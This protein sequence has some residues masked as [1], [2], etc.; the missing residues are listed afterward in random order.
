MHKDKLRLKYWAKVIASSW[1]FRA[2]IIFF[3]IESIWIALSGQYPMA[4]DEDFHLGIIRLYASHISPFW[5]SQPSNADRFGAVARDP[6]YLYQYLM[7]FPYRF[8]SLFTKDQT[9]MVILL[10]FIDI[11]FFGSSLV[12]FKR[13]MLKCGASATV[14]N[15]CLLL[16]VLLPVTPLLAAQINYDDLLMPLVAIAL[17]L[18]LRFDDLISRKKKID[19]K[20]GLQLLIICELASLV[21]YAFLPIFITIVGFLVI[22][23]WRNHRE[24]KKI[25]ANIAIDW[26]KISLKVRLGLSIA[27][28]I[29][30]GLFL[31][32]YGVNIVLYHT[33]TPDCAQ[34]LTV[35][36]CSQYGPWIRNYT[37]ELSNVAGPHN[38]ITFTREW[39]YGMW[40]RT[41]FSV[42]GSNINYETRGPLVLPGIGSIVLCA[43]GGLGFLLSIKRLFKKYKSSV[44]WL[45]LSSS[46]I[47]IAF[48]WFDNYQAYIDTG[49]PVAINGRYLLPV[50]LPLILIAILSLDI[51]LKRYMYIYALIAL[52]AIIC[53]AWGGGTLTYILRSNNQWNW[54]NQTVYDANDDIQRWVGP[55]VPG[56]NHPTQFLH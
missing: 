45:Y 26:R 39:F 42:A 32:R 33:P 14:S 31:Q 1:F 17:L 28:I 52:S 10:R 30:T 19:I 11:G 25:K 24:I 54:P 37:Y 13:L 41:F 48:L 29:A 8:I 35:K 49:Q 16:F 40:L 53:L 44:L 50:L 47:Y 51:L 5:S 46:L 22:R 3:F 23:F 27:F 6:S 7:S 21:K 56:Y 55:L 38:P 12:L 36:Q 34:I 9:I 15:F 18:T 43:I 20:T 2:V 4:F